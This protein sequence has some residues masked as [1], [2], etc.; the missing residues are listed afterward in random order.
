MEVNIIFGLLLLHIGFA[1]IEAARNIYH[2][3]WHDLCYNL[4]HCL[5][6]CYILCHCPFLL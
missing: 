6:L 4:C 3:F 5:Y 2:Y 1:L